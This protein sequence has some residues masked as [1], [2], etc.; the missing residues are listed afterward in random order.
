MYDCQP[1]RGQSEE[2]TAACWSLGCYLKEKH[3]HAHRS[4]HTRSLSTKR[5]YPIF[6]PDFGSSHFLRIE[7]SLTSNTWILPCSQASSLS[8]SPPV[9][10]NSLLFVLLL[11]FFPAK[12]PGTETKAE[13]MKKGKSDMWRKPQCFLIFSRQRG[14]PR[15]SIPFCWF[16]PR[17]TSTSHNLYPHPDTNHRLN[18]KLH[19]PSMTILQAHPQVQ[20][21]CYLKTRQRPATTTSAALGTL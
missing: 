6:I 15:A 11:L 4:M 7:T 19:V 16:P 17:Q 12:E 13:R 18:P 1:S 20:R 21:C 2:T 8:R 5:N 9:C 10:Y 14:R 3:T